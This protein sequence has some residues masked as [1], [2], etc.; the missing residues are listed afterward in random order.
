MSCTCEPDVRIM[1]PHAPW[2]CRINPTE[3]ERDF[4]PDCCCTL[5]SLVA[6]CPVHAWLIPLAEGTEAA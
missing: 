2:D 1:L 6:D 3:W 4:D 5:I